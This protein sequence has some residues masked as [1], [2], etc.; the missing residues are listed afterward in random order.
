MRGGAAD[1]ALID[2]SG[3][4]L[5][6]REGNFLTLCERGERIVAC[7]GVESY[8]GVGIK[9]IGERLVGWE[10]RGSTRGSAGGA[11]S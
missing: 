6:G 4:I 1:V 11:R 9:R 5:K 10:G 2:V 7:E 8:N 3:Y